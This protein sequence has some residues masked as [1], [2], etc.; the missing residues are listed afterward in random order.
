MKVYAFLLLLAFVVSC[1]TGR[2]TTTVQKTIELPQSVYI[3]SDGSTPITGAEFVSKDNPT[4]TFTKYG[5]KKF[6]KTGQNVN[7][8]YEG[9]SPENSFLLFESTDDGYYLQLIRNDA[10]AEIHFDRLCQTFI[11]ADPAM[12]LIT[13]SDDIKYEQIVWTPRKEGNWEVRIG[14]TTRG[15]KSE[16]LDRLNKLR[17]SEYEK[18]AKS[19]IIK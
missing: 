14:S 9:I 16:A 13:I 4:I 2:H 3:P 11:V 5:E 7:F 15:C 1:T 6:V 8:I 12:T 18:K 10:P 17:T 19:T